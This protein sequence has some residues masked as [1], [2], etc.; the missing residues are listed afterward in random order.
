MMK[1]VAGAGVAIPDL[2]ADSRFLRTYFASKP[3]QRELRNPHPEK[4]VGQAVRNRA[5][6][7]AV[8]IP[9]VDYPDSP[10]LLVTRRHRNIRFAGHICFPGGRADTGDPSDV[11]TALRETREEIGLSLED[12]EVLGTLGHYYTQAGYRIT[13]VVGLIHPPIHVTA[14]P[15]EVEEII[16]VPLKEAFKGANY[17]VTWHAQGRGHIAFIHGR[18]RIAGPT[19]SVLIGLYERLAAFRNLAYADDSSS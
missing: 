2:D 11:A 8:L 1:R 15:D 6:R 16:E 13:P 14:N 12:V 17:H 10:M 4:K 19:V 9:V 18:V 7:A 5:K 3:D